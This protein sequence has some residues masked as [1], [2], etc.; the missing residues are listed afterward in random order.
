MNH[1]RGYGL[2]VVKRQLGQAVLGIQY[3]TLFGDF[4]PALQGA[5]G[6]GQD[7]LVSRPSASTDRPTAAVEEAKRHILAAGERLK[8]DLS[9]VNLPVAGEK[10]G[11][12]IAV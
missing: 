9:L 3:F 6:L 2:Q 1:G 12:L 7:R 11:I 10:A 5:A 4:D 8:C